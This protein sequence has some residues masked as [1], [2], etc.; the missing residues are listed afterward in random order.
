MNASTAV[1]LAVLSTAAKPPANYLSDVPFVEGGTVV[2]NYRAAI[3][4]KYEGRSKLVGVRYENAKASL[5]QLAVE[6]EKAG[7]FVSRGYPSK[8]EYLGRFLAQKETKRIAA[9]VPADTPAVV[10]ILFIPK[11]P[12]VR[13][14][15][16]KMCSLYATAEKQ[17]L[18]GDDVLKFMH[19]R[20]P[21]T[22]TATDNVHV[23]LLMSAMAVAAPEEAYEFALHSARREHKLHDWSCPA[24]G[25]LF[26]L[27]D[28]TLFPELRAKP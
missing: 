17:K 12:T 5:E 18:A 20:N 26:P 15:L 11:T 14:D 21:D 25:R 23:Q 24:L 16:D 7:W 13:E 8:G 28:E 2:E 3:P 4:K 10:E 22:E 1:L 9:R 19:E 6:L 27:G